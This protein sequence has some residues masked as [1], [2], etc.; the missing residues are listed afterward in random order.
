MQKKILELSKRATKYFSQK[1]NL[2][3]S[4]CVS[5][6]ISYTGYYEYTGYNEIVYT[7][8]WFA[9]FNLTDTVS[10]DWNIR[11]MQESLE[12]CHDLDM[13][14]DMLTEYLDDLDR[15]DNVRLT[16]GANITEEIGFGD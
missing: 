15:I 5:V 12:E 4:I 3:D 1:Y 2:D 16:D 14:L 10:A 8:T 11:L 7:Q 13:C 9:A 6:C